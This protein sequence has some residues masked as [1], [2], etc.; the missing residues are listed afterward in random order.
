MILIGYSGHA[1]VICDALIENGESV[2]GYCDVKEKERNP[3]NLKYLGYESDDEVYA[4]IKQCH[5]FVAVGNNVNRKEITEK[6][7]S[8]LEQPDN[9]FSKTAT[10]SSNASFGKGVFV[11]TKAII[12]ALA[13]ISDGV[14]CNTGSI[15]E[16][17][18]EIGAY[19]S[20]GSGAV[21]GGNVKI[22]ESTLIGSNATI[23]KGLTIGKNVVIGAGTV[24]V[25]DVPDSLVVVGNPQRILRENK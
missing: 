3:Y 7:I 1:F 9:I 17:E 8:K 23:R 20:I 14:I 5:Y 24:I 21:L 13:A 4:M 15:I 19:A 11:G 18:C 10:I 2:V 16:H 6:L 12:N 25:K 22:G